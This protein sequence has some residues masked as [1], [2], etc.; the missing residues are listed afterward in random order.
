LIRVKKVKDTIDGAAV[1]KWM[2]NGKNANSNAA[3]KPAD[4]LPVIFFVIQNIKNIE[5]SDCSNEKKT[6][7]VKD[8]PKVEYINNT[9]SN[10]IRLP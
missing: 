6:L 2:S 3:T 8:I 7:V 10:W 1:L 4:W 5:V 9:G